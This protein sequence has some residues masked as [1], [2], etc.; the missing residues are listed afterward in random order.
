MKGKVVL[1]LTLFLLSEG[2]AYAQP[3]QTVIG[4]FGNWNWYRRDKLVNPT[5]VQYAKYTILN[6]SF[7]LPDAEGGINSSDGWADEN[8]LLGEPDWSTTP[9]GRKPNTSMIDLA[10][11][12]ACKIVP[13]IGGWSGSD[14]FS[15]IAAQPAKS[16][17]FAHACARLCDSLH[18]D[19]I[20]ID[21]EY[22]GVATR[23][24]TPADWGNYISFLQQIRDSLSAL[25]NRTGKHY[26]L[27]A[28]V[29]ASAETMEKIDWAKLVPILDYINL[30]TYDFFGPWDPIA[31]HNA[32]LYAPAQGDSLFNAASAVKALTEH[33]QVPSQKLNMGVAFYGRALKTTQTPALFAP[34]TGTADSETFPDDLGIPTYYDLLPKLSLFDQKWDEV[35]QVPYLVGLNGLNTFVS[36]D[37]ERSI[38][39]KGQFIKDH[40]LAGAIIWELTGDYIQGST[41]GT[42]QA[43]P[44][45]DALNGALCSSLSL[46]DVPAAPILSWDMYPN[47]AFHQVS[48]RNKGEE[49]YVLEIRNGLGELV[50]TLT[51]PA[52]DEQ[53]ISVEN[54]AEGLYVIQ[55]KDVRSQQTRKLLVSRGK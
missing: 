8:L 32:P 33:Y 27:T 45:L 43:T 19:G 35:A 15:D 36:Y 46:E 2:R 10:H 3:C 17:R 39:T 24:G 29:G 54:W 25:G 47:P 20:D 52:Q 49:T 34:L 41:A 30:M 48:F 1:F 38:R 28:A 55:G 11:L 51:L 7:Y 26:L 13:S 18:F 5:T 14:H 6:Y 9:V 44:L 21:W 40:H 53:R 42:I 22:P 37:D 12:N 50:Q 23:A 16:A 4:Y 31:N